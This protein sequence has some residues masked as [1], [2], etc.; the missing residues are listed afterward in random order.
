MKIE[1]EVS[2]LN[3]DAWL[4]DYVHTAV[5]FA[6]WH[7]EQRIEHARVALHRSSDRVRCS[8][9]LDLPDGRVLSTHAAGATA[10][11]A[12]QDACD[13]LEVE[14]YRSGAAAAPA[15]RGRLAA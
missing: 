3:V 10:F 13:R 14:L 5:V 12:L 9:R 4:R 1:L 11:D 8:L 2:G 6:T 15:A 7:H